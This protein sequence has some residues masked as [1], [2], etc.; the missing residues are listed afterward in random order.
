M[1]NSDQFIYYDMYTCEKK[2]Y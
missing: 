2:N 1:S